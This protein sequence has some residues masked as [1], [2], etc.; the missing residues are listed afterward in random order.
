M[1]LFT[2][3]F[4]RELQIFN[5]LAKFKK[6]SDKR[7][8]ENYSRN[9]FPLT[10][11]LIRLRLITRTSCAII[12]SLSSTHV[13]QSHPTLSS[14]LDFDLLRGFSFKRQPGTLKNCISCAF[15]C[16]NSELRKHHGVIRRIRLHDHLK[17]SVRDDSL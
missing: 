12:L 5:K 7:K 6:P 14:P 10:M 3:S 9:I 15:K 13:D 4:Y 8:G 17:H 16:R 11:F 2:L 1:T